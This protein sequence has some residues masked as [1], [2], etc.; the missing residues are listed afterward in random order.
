MKAPK[1]FL[2]GDHY[3]IRRRVPARYAP[4]EPR[5]YVHICLYTDSPKIAA[6]KAPEIWAQMI[7]GWE[8]MLEGH[9]AEG[10]RRLKAAHN[11][12]QRRGYR[13][14]EADAVAKLPLTEILKR[15][16]S[17]VD[18]RDR[19][20][21]KEADAALGIAPKPSLTVKEAVDEFYK[22]AADRVQ[23]KN[24]DQMRRHKA[25]RK[26]ATRNFIEAVENKPLSEITTDDM[27]A[28][29]AWWLERVAKGEVLAASANKDFTYLAA[30]WRAV[31]RVKRIDLKFTTDGLA[32]SDSAAKKRTR[33]PFSDEWITGTLLKDG[34]LNGLNADAR[35]ILLGMINTG[36]RPSEGAGLLPKEIKLDGKV[37]HILIQPND[38]RAL[39]NTHSERYI[40][41]TGISLEAFREM[42]NGFPRY[43]SN[44]ATLSATVN[45]FLVENKLLESDRHSFYGLRHSFEDRLLVAGIDERIRR[46]LMGHGLKRERYGLGGDMAHVH[47]LM[48]PIAL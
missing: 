17:V 11:L 20:N 19:L 6:H 9:D 24:D 13:Y 23:G 26:K 7:E 32:L 47:G 5:G 21:M 34:A 44:S 1:P 33:V 10:E 29:R 35:Y 38:N 45:K 22:V 48:S 25:P 12:A 43:A 30:M 27:F 37:P 4:V 8:A 28:F 46:D 2:R 18:K 14:L 16:E 42:K 36:Y 3:Y 39:K 41:L 40:P 31:A 15:V